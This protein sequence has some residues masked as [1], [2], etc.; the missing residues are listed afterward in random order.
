[1]P[2]KH[3]GETPWEIRHLIPCI[4]KVAALAAGLEGVIILLLIIYYGAFGSLV[5][6]RK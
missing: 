3:E 5:Y 4:K 1:M 2:L 6:N